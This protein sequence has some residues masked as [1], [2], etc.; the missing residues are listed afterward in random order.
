MGH[1]LRLCGF[2]GHMIGTDISTGMLSQARERR[3]YEQ[4]VAANANEGLTVESSSIDLVICVGAMELLDHRT[5]L[6]EFARILRPS[7]QL[8]AS[9]QWEDAVDESGSAVPSPTEHQHIA[10]LEAAGFDT[11]AGAIEKSGCAFYTP[12]PKQDGSL[13]PVPYLYVSVGLRVEA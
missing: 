4:L 10:E 2:R 11:N 9:F 5:V 12:S 1:M 6:S 13:L 3:M 8:W 7:G